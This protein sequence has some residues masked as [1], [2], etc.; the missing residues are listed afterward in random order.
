[1]HTSCPQVFSDPD[2]SVRKACGLAFDKVEFM[3]GLRPV[4]AG[5]PDFMNEET[6]QRIHVIKYV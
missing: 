1:M 3:A 4:K 6:G 5:L 2:L